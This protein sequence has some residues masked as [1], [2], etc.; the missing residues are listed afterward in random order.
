VS[1]STLLAGL[2]PAV[3]DLV[4]AI[5]VAVSGSKTKREAAYKASA[6]IA[7]ALVWR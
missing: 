1:A 2:A 4:L 6:V 3:R 5:I 7:K